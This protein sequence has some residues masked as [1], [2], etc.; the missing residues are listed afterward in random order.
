[1]DE[2]RFVDFLNQIQDDNEKYNLKREIFTYDQINAKVKTI[3]KE[4]FEFLKVI[5]IRVFGSYFNGTRNGYSDI[6]FLI[7]M[8]DKN[9][10]FLISSLLG[11]SFTD[12]FGDYVD[13]HVVDPRKTLNKVFIK[14]KSIREMR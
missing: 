10:D 12:L 3:D 11:I 9:C 5:D 13:T 2:N 7:V 6:N 1:M 14:S 8:D 4:L